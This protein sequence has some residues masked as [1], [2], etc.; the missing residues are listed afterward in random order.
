[1]GWILI[2]P[3]NDAELAAATDLLR[4]IGECTFE[5]TKICARLKLV[6]LGSRPCH[7][8]KINFHSF[9]GEASS[10]RW[11]ISQNKSYLLGDHFY[12][13]CDRSAVKEVLEYNGSI[14]MICR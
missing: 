9:T 3:N 8:N 13:M 7:E 14:Q 11:A 12:W 4:T 2:Q 6:A 1:M 5:F 10:G